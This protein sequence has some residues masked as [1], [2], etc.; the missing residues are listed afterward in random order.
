MGLKAQRLRVA[1]RQGGDP[2][3]W[4]PCN[5]CRHPFRLDRL[6]LSHIKALGMGRSRR[7]ASDQLNADTNKEL[8]CRNCHQAHELRQGLKHALERERLAE[9]LGR[10]YD[11]PTDE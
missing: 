4:V 9:V 11:E 3:G 2:M 6:D 7:D 10:A 5:H 8:L 1:K